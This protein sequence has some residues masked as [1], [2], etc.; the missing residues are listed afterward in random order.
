MIDMNEGNLNLH[1]SLREMKDDKEKF[2][3]IYNEYT[4]KYII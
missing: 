2:I 3:D 1:E 4:Q